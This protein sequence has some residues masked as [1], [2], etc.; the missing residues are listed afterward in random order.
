MQLAIVVLFAICWGPTLIDNVLVEF[1]ILGRLS[2]GYLKYMRQ[3]FV[4]MSYFNSCVNPVVYAFMSKN[5][6]AGLRHLEELLCSKRGRR[7]QFSRRF[8]NT[9]SNL[10]DFG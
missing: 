6:R 9:Q 7:Q 2:L 10:A 3:A 8:P 5:F 1:Q 4:L